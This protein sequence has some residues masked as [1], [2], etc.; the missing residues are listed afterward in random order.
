M[1]KSGNLNIKIAQLQLSM[2]SEDIKI[3]KAGHLPIINLVGTYLLQGNATLTQTDSPQ[4]TEI[5]SLLSTIPG[6]PLS[7]YT[8]AAVGLQLIVPISSGGGI[9]SKVRQAID[10]YEVAD[11]Q[12]TTISRQTDQNI[13]YAYYQVLNGVSTVKAQTQALKSAKLK[14]DSDKV[15]YLVGI[16]NSVDL[17]TSQKNYTQ[18]ILNYNDARYKY[19]NY[20]L[21]LEYLSGKI[22][23]E[24]LNFINNN[25]SQ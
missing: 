14:L 4:T 7:S 15:G 6:V 23:E 19:L 18:A 12:I 8:G 9:T 20:Q 22:S 13:R 3:A 24:Y 5:F 10:N 11:Q 1:A 21:Q 17:I 2:A 16:R 25:I